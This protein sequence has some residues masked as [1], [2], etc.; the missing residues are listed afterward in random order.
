MWQNG[1]GRQIWAD[2]NG[3]GQLSPE[4][5]VVETESEV[6]VHRWVPSFVN[7]FVEDKRMMKEKDEIKPAQVK[8]AQKH[9]LR[10]CV[11]LME[12][13]NPLDNN[14]ELF[15]FWY[16]VLMEAKVKDAV[17]DTMSSEH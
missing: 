8:T 14:T 6:H 15:Q 16:G 9:R 11:S 10:K 13:M 4:N 12:S 5:Y 3:R 7:Q 17:V 1:R 2:D